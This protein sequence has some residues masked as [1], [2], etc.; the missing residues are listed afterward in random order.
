MMVHPTV[1]ERLSKNSSKRIPDFGSFGRV[2][3][4]V[5]ERIGET[6]IWDRGY[7]ECA[8]L[9]SWE[10]IRALQEIGV[11]FGCHSLTHRPMTEMN[12]SE[13]VEDMAR[14]RAILE[15]GLAARVTVLA[16]PYGA[17]NE[18]VRCVVEDLGFLAALTCKP[19]ISRLGDNLLKLPRIEVF[20][21]C[22]PDQLLSLVD[23][24]G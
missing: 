21:D 1:Q 15:E 10:E 2:T 16:Y 18:Y 6:A 7:G 17:Q 8:P 24:P 19:G 3:E 4:G 22:S 11:E 5:A 12:L 14:A 13:L 9:L 20:G 23:Y